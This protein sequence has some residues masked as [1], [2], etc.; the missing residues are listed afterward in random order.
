MQNECARL[1]QR[2]CKGYIVSKRYEKV[3][4]KY[5][6]DYRLEKFIQLK[7]EIKVQLAHLLYFTWKCYKGR[8]ARLIRED[9]ARKAALAAAKKKKKRGGNR[10]KS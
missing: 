8:K 3:R 2:L 4:S 6:I 9:A 7:E 1:I 10:N 5:L